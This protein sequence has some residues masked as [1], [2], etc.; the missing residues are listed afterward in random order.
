MIFFCED[1]GEKNDLIPS[2][3]KDGKAIFRCGS[4]NYLNSYIFSSPKEKD[5]TEIKPKPDK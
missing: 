4:C 2:Q 3:F 5:M 1:C